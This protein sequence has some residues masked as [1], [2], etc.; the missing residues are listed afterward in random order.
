[1]MAEK[2]HKPHK[3]R[4]SAGILLYRSGPGGVFEVL[5][6]HPGGPYYARKDE[7]YWTIPKGEPEPGEELRNAAFREFGEETS[8][9]L[10]PSS[11]TIPLGWIQQ[12]GGKIVHAWAAQGDV[13]P[14]EVRSNRI[15]IEWPP[16]TGRMIEI[17][18][19]D[20]VEWFELGE[21]RRKIKPAQEAFL[22]RLVA[23]LQVPESSNE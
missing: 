6:A 21:A 7:G 15:T 5:L 1:M 22:D 17:P 20:R 19:I 18:E 8:L 12:K 3:S 11:A 16:R 13:D 10:D 9:Q 14:A 23:T 4:L 2:P